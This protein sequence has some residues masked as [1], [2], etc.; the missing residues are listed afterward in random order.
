MT[1]TRRM[2]MCRSRVRFTPRGAPLLTYALAVGLALRRLLVGRDVDPAPVLHARLIQRPV[3]EQSGASR[4]VLDVTLVLLP[5]VG[6]P[7]LHPFLVGA[8]AATP[9]D[10]ERGQQWQCEPQDVAGLGSPPSEASERE[11]PEPQ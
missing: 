10:H 5:R 6:L 1:A 8:S 2:R 7:D 4:A 3:A 11:R 9:H